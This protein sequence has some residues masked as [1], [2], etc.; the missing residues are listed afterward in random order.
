MLGYRKDIS[1]L[2]HAADIFCFPSIRE[3]L[4]LAAI[5]AMACGLPI[6]TSAIRG[7]NDYSVDGATGYACP[8]LDVDAFAKAIDTLYQ[9]SEM[10]HVMG[11]QNKLRAQK[12]DIQ[13]ILPQ[14]RKIYQLEEQEK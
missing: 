4:G 9:N 1:E 12:Y 8:P 10:R 13:S 11:S 14:M 2:N 3:G 6:A 5:E 7:I